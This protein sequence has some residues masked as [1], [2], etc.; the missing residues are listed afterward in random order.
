MKKGKAL[1]KKVRYMTVWVKRG[2]TWV[3]AAEQSTPIAG[4]R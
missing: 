3:V 2:D 1:Q 4:D